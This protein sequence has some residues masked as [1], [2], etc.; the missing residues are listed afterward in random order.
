MAAKSTKR[1]RLPLV[2]SAVLALVIRRPSHGYEISNRYERTYSMFLPA[3]RASVYTALKRLERQGLIESIV[4]ISTPVRG[5]TRCPFR[6]TPAGAQVHKQW[7]ASE[8]HTIDA[9]DL[10]ARVAATG[11]LGTPTIRRVL[12]NYHSA[13]TSQ[14]EDLA[15]SAGG[16]DR[17]SIDALATQLIASQKLCLLNA[18]LAWLNGPANDIITSYEQALSQE[19]RE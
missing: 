12:S 5:G 1:P 3:S 14:A 16:S 10:L 19:R 18:A 8:I 17:R 4:S 9:A 6:A 13:C 15:K 2:Q 11:V 7:L